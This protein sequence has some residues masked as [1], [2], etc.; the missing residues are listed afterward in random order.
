MLK[1]IIFVLAI[2]L[3]L[4]FAFSGVAYANFGPHGGYTEDTDA[5]AGCHRAHTSFST[6]EW[7]DRFGSTGSALLIGSAT[8][9]E[10]FCN[11]CHGDDAPGAST[12]VVSGVFDGGPSGT[13]TQTVGDVSLDGST[14]IA[15]TTNS[16]F[17]AT[18]NGGGFVSMPV[19]AANGVFTAI[20]S[21]HGM[22]ALNVPLW[23]DN[24]TMVGNVWPQLICTSC[25]DVHGS[26]NYRLLKDAVNGNTVGGYD[27]LDNPLP[28][29]VS[30]EEGYPLS[31]WFKHEPG[32]AQ[33]AG[34]NPNYTTEEY[35]N[36][37]L[38]RENISG[39]CSSCHE[40][41]IVRN[42]ASAT[43][44]WGGAGR[45]LFADMTTDNYNYDPYLVNPG[46][47]DTVGAQ[48]FHRH[49]MNI[50]LAGGDPNGLYWLN[51]PVTTDAV[52][53]LEWDGSGSDADFRAGEWD[54]T[55]YLGC[56]T[57]HRAHGTAVT[58][59]GWASAHIDT[60]NGTDWFPVRDASGGV[61][62]VFDSALLRADDRGVCERC[63]NK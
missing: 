23:G 2:A 12:N 53:P 11:A 25:H 44:L 4:T 36:T 16:S 13:S 21:S 30:A 35:R 41:Y 1:R 52:L 50:T 58:M 45:G 34:Y 18:L 37:G 57:C 61:D 33:I 40:R 6:L 60:T 42:D 48:V 46:V 62:P 63:H 32:A 22:E 15:Y 39:W 8:T 19:D 49:P 10:D 59:T 17:D 51:T 20:S 24:D 5:C 43:A 3:A 31:G 55:D 7:T 56:L 29:V 14:V 28:F 47:T 27:A 54:Y 9:M 26:S 38:A